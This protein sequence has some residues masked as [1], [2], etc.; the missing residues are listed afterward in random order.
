MNLTTNEY[1]IFSINVKY[2]PFQT[3]GWM[4]KKE[5][6]FNLQGERS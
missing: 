5:I 1:T 6:Y 2:I 3:H 4:E